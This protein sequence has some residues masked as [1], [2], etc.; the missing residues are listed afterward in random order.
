MKAKE[1]FDQ[2]QNAESELK[3]LNAKLR[4]YEEIGLS[5]GG[6]PGIVGGGQKGTSRVELAACGA[7][8]ALDGP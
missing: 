4:H 2:V 1:F 3:V 7:V 6:A 8:D 5:F